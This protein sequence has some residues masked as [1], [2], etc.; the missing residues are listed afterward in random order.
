MSVANLVSNGLSVQTLDKVRPRIA[1]L[2][3]ITF[4]TVLWI[5]A[6]LATRISKLDVTY[7]PLL[8]E[9]PWTF[10][11]GFGLLLVAT[12]QWLLAV[13]DTERF[14]FLLLILWTAYLFI[15]PELMEINARVNDTY[16]W[17]L[18]VTYLEEGRFSVAEGFGYAVF[19]G[20]F[21]I[22]FAISKVC[23]IGYYHMAPF[24]ASALHLF[25][26]V[27]IF[28]FASMLYVERRRILFASLLLT[29]ML[30]MPGTH[31]SPHGMGFIAL[32]FVYALAFS[33]R[34]IGSPRYV[35]FALACILAVMTHPV[36]SLMGLLALSLMILV[37]RFVKRIEDTK[38][39]S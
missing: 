21:F 15:G 26:A 30:W 32:L 28:G 10:W 17:L 19:P 7:F 6:V 2:C 24:L 14:H 39:K 4:S 31:P 34:L 9:L 29:A 5:A 16:D 37:P 33:E 8:R 12:A 11:I 27:A 18:G 1:F 22:S 36:A 25:R 35:L 23:G 38:L 13:T 3:L 20:Y